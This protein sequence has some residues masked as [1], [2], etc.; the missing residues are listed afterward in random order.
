MHLLGWGQRMA[1]TR[2]ICRLVGYSNHRCG[3]YFGCETYFPNSSSFPVIR[4]QGDK[5]MTIDEFTLR[6]FVTST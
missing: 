3:G 4:K 2:H 6:I 1:L 5:Y